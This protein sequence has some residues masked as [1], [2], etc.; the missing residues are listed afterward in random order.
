MDHQRFDNLARLV[1]KSD[2]RR[3]VIRMLAAGTVGLIVRLGSGQPGAAQP[4]GVPL[5]GLCTTTEECRL[6]IGPGPGSYNTICG[7]NGVAEDGTLNCCNPDGGACC[8]TDADCCGA[9]V[10]RGSGRF[11]LGD[12]I[13]GNRCIPPEE[14][15]NPTGTTLDALNLRSGPGLEHPTVLVIPAGA[16]VTILGEVVENGYILVDYQGTTG[17][18][19]IEFLG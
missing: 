5:G 10:C 15:S 17:W 3:R 16:I 19:S 7:D 18:V 4:V 6:R 12:D 2:S 1:A 9:L 11:G 14:A 8:S 13:C